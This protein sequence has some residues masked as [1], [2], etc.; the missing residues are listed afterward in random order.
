MLMVDSGMRRG[1]VRF[2]ARSLS[3]NSRAAERS[4]RPTRLF[5]SFFLDID[6]QTLDLLVQGGKWDVEALGRVGLIPVTLFQ[7]LDDDLP[8]AIFHDV[9]E[10]CVGATF[11]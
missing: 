9:E 10:R 2:S 3:T 1:E 4:L 11:N 8:L 7:H 5:S 6:V